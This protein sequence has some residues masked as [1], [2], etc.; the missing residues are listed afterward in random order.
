VLDTYQSA[1]AMPLEYERWG[2]SFGVGGSVKWLCG[3]PGAGYLYVRPDLRDRLEPRLT[4]WQAHARPFA[5][6]TGAIDYAESSMLRYAHGTPAVPALVSAAASYRVIREIGADL[7]RARSLF[8]TQYLIDKAQ[9]RGLTVSSETRPER[10]GGSVV[11]KVDDES[12]M[13]ERLA[14]Q[15]IIVDSRPGV[16]VRAGPHVFNTLEDLDTLIDALAP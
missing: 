6:E 11:I 8:L 12:G 7:I 13:E 15:R 16:G 5:F 1:G 10:R 9:E 14:A 3:G 2:I 4:G